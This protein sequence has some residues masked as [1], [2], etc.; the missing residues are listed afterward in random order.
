MHNKT[1]SLG[2]RTVSMGRLLTSAERLARMIDP[3][4]RARREA[5]RAAAAPG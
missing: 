4:K 2:R 5:E 1:V 3:G